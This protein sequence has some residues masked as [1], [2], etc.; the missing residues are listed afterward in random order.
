[1]IGVQRISTG[2]RSMHDGSM[3]EPSGVWP[4]GLR[5][6]WFWVEEVTEKGRLCVVLKDGT[7]CLCTIYKL[8]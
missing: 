2:Y 1:M 3:H 8:K 7:V 5:V 6:Q 4:F